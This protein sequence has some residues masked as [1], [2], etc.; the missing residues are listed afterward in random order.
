MGGGGGS[1]YPNWK[2]DQLAA[3]VRKDAEDSAAATKVFDRSGCVI[4][5]ENS[6]G[7]AEPCKT[8]RD[9]THHRRYKISRGP[10]APRHRPGKL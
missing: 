6:S 10:I 1:S 9:E 3:A 5:K 2:S 8:R 7:K 4:I